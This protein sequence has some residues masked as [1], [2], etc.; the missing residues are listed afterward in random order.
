[1]LDL[2]DLET[3]WYNLG[4]DAEVTHTPHLFLFSERVVIPDSGLWAALA[5]A[6][7]IGPGGP[8]LLHLQGFSPGTSAHV[9]SDLQKQV[10]FVLMVSQ[11]L[12]E[13]K[14]NNSFHFLVFSFLRISRSHLTK[15][16]KIMRR[17]CKC[18]FVL[19]VIHGHEFPQ[20]E[21][22]TEPQWDNILAMI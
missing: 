4:P 17:S 20:A 13:G 3:E 14:M 10:G 9:V 22:R 18:C 2:H 12:I 21:D 7:L 5:L 16:G 8:T 6:A 11:L 1:M 15:P 19:F